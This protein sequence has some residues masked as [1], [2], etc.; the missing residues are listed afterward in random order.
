MTHTQQAIAPQPQLIRV[1]LM[2]LL[3]Q[4]QIVLL[5]GLEQFRC[6]QET[7][8]AAESGLL[9]ESSQTGFSQ[10]PAPGQVSHSQGLLFT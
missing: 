10:L 8:V 2:V 7:A 5:L 9:N 6:Q 1:L 4:G 3:Q